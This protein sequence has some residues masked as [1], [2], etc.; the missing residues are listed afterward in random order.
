M[1]CEIGKT[2][3][4]NVKAGRFYIAKLMDEDDTFIKFVDKHDRVVSVSKS[5]ISE[6]TTWADLG[7]LGN[8]HSP[9]KRKQE[10]K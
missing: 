1:L 10:K 7:F 5:E 2:Y 4:I 3:K 8:Y 6:I 9:P